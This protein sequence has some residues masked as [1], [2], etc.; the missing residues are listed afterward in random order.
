VLERTAADKGYDRGEDRRALHEELGVAPVIPARD[1]KQG[2]IQPLN[3]QRSDTI[4]VSAI[5]N[6]CWRIAPLAPNTTGQF[7]AM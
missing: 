5:G 1:L 7:A 3:D 6:I 4:Y 2:A